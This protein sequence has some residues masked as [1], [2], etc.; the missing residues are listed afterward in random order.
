MPDLGQ[1][2][3]RLTWTVVRAASGSR[4][5]RAP[6]TVTDFPRKNSFLPRIRIVPLQKK[7]GRKKTGKK[8]NK[9]KAESWADSSKKNQ[10]ELIP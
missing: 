1:T 8:T 9:E 3:R 5:R 4:S 2:K 10:K 6:L 7:K